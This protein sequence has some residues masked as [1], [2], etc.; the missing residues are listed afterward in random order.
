MKR[1]KNELILFDLLFIFFV[2]S[3]CMTIAFDELMKCLFE[4]VFLIKLFYVVITSQ[5]LLLVAIALTIKKI[6]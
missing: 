3:V 4:D 2:L 1:S 5:V 6:K